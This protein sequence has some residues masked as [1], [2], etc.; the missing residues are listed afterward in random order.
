[1]KSSARR[2]LARLVLAALLV[3]PGAGALAS[4]VQAASPRAD[5]R[6][7]SETPFGLAGSSPARLFGTGSPSA[8]QALLSRTTALGSSGQAGRGRA[9][10]APPVAGSVGPLLPPSPVQASSTAAPDHHVGGFSGLAEGDQAS[11]G[12]EPAESTVA[13]GPEQIVQIANLAMRITDRDG[14]AALDVPVPT[15]FLVTS[16]FFDRDPRV[17]YDSFHGRF[18]ATETSWDCMTNTYPGDPAVFGHGYIDLAVS[19]TNDPSGLWN[20]YF[21]AYND[22]LPGDPSPGTSTDK[23][24]VSDNLLAMSHSDGGLTDGSCAAPASLSPFAGDLQITSWADAVAHKST[25]LPSTEYAGGPPSSPSATVLGVRAALQVPATSATLFVVARSVASDGM[26]TLPN[27]VIVTT[28]KGLPSQST[29]VQISGSWDLTEAGIMAA[30]ANPPAPHQ[31]GSPATIANAANGDPENALWQAGL[32]AWATTY[33]CTPSGDSSQRDCVRVSQVNTANATQVSPPIQTQDFL[34]A[35]NGFDSF[36]PGIGLS[37]DGTLDVVYTRSNA[38][39]PNYPSSFEQYQRPADGPNAASAAVQLAAGT[40]TYPGSDWGRYVGLGQDPQLP[41]AVWQANAFSA[42]AGFWSTFVDLLGPTTATTYVPISP[43]RIVDSRDGSGLSGLSGKFASAVPRTFTVAGLGMIPGNAVA[44]TG[45]VTATRQTKAGYVAVTPT[46]QTSPTSSTVNFPVADNRANNLTVPLSSGG[47]LSA[48]Y[49]ASAGKTTDVVFDVTGYFVPNNTGATYHPLAPVRMLDSRVG[50]GQPGG[51]PARFLTGVPQ[52][53]T[54]GDGLTVPAAATAI[55]GNLTV[56]AQTKSGFLSITPDPSPSP[57]VSNLNFPTG[58][59]RANGF[60]APLN[61]SHQLSIVYVAA[62]GAQ[63]DV[64]LDV[65]GYYLADLSGLHFYPVNP[66][67]IMDTR[68]GV[69]NSGLTGT[70]ATSVPRELPTSGHWAIPDDAQTVTGQTGLG[71]VAI[72]PAS[73]ADPTTSTLNFPVAD[74]RAN[75]VTV[76]LS[77]TGSLW[78]VYK[79]AT[80]KTTQLILDLSGYFR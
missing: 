39:A 46:P 69:A 32:L 4:S 54:I 17:V 68:A 78:L 63:T 57:G 18:V 56:A 11:A 79:A 10:T 48:T 27:D 7:A 34:L 12:V 42:G 62:A 64:I 24:A 28:F 71:F 67:R 45:N 2:T 21:W 31:P 53:F 33:P 36:V 60:T 50:T 49:I 14:T 40:G 1:M 38:T 74:N 75:G 70:F 30:F 19:Q 77:G 47:S 44:V 65:T 25:S 59:N 73:N 6:S 61:G 55:T 76:P 72:T 66:G 5:G 20:L 35:R 13:I 41:S 9:P 8:R 15:F 80:G 52:T 3:G 37:G 58:D 43:I 26:G 22:L 29:S 16:G 23:L 51:V